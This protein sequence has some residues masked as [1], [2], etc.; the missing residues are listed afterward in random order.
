MFSFFKLGMAVLFVFVNAFFVAV[1][2][3][4]VRIRRT[5]LEELSNMG[6][7][8]ADLLLKVLASLDE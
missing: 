2:F 1:E 7:K 3:S 4:F 8:K 5:R 6:N